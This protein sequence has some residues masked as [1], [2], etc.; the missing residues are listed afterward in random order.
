MG[1]TC[2]KYGRQDCCIEVLVEKPEGKRPFRRPKGS[3]EDNIKNGSLRRW[4]G[5]WSGSI[6][7]GIG[8][9]GWLV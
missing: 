1:R 2:R 5:A 8:R 7:L 9:G 6:W 3:W 4:M